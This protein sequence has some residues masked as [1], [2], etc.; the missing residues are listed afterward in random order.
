MLKFLVLQGGN[1]NRPGR[2]EPGF[3]ES[4]KRALWH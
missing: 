2:C 3:Y 1:M 4:C